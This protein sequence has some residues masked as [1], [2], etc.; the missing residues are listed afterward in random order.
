MEFCKP[1]LNSDP[2]DDKLEI[3]VYTL[4]VLSALTGDTIHIIPIYAQAALK[5]VPSGTQNP[6]KL[7]KI[8]TWHKRNLLKT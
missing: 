5:L 8:S 4:R 6:R 7:L 2:V 3:F 1:A